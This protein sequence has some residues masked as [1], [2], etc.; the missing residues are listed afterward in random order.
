MCRA[1]SAESPKVNT[2]KVRSYAREF[3]LWCYMVINESRT[4]TCILKYGLLTLLR[5]LAVHVQHMGVT[6]SKS[7]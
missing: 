1:P 3:I 7:I 6:N 5:S 2:Q 4:M